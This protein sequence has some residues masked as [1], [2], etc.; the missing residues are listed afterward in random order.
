ML[1]LIRIISTR[2]SITRH[3]MSLQVETLEE[4][5]RFV[6]LRT[7]R[8]LPL[9]GDN[10]RDHCTFNCLQM[11]AWIPK[12]TI[13]QGILSPGTILFLVMSTIGSSV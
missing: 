12:R 1:Q 2:G 5:H 4:R 9:H 11:V 7:M 13:H 6:P 10:V 3:H 8:K